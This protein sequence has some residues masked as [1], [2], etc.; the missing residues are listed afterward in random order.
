MTNEELATIAMQHQDRIAAFTKWSESVDRR[1]GLLEASRDTLT[2]VQISLTQ[3]DAA[4]Q[5]V[6][7]IMNDMKKTLERIDDDN[8]K[9]YEELSRR[10]RALEDAPGK[11]WDKAVWIVAS[12]LIGAAVSYFLKLPN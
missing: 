2:K 1:I 9:R 6:G 4:T 7:E 8:K 10:V 3:L 5:R 11:K 12:L